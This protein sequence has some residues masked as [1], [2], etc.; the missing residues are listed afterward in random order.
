MA[1][2]IFERERI[3]QAAT[4]ED[5]ALLALEIGNLLD[6]PQGLGMRAAG[7][8]PAFEQACCVLRRDRPVA[9]AA[10]SRLDFN[11]RLEPEEP[12][13]AGAHDH[14][15]DP[16]RLR[17]ARERLGDAVRSDRQRRRVA[18]KEDSRA[19]CV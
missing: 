17:F 14:D 5:E 4:G 8:E 11:E 9:D 7:Q 12:A 3:G 15:L 10:R 16:A 13:R 19:H 18:R 1:A 6:P 2:I